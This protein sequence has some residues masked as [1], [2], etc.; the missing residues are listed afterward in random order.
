MCALDAPVIVAAQLKRKPVRRRI[1]LIVAGGL[2]AATKPFLVALA[3]AVTASA[4]SD[5]SLC[6]QTATP[7]SA[8]ETYLTGVKTGDRDLVL[9]VYYF[10]DGNEDFSLAAPMP[11]E[12][13]VIVSETVF[14][15]LAA[16]QWND[17]GIKPSAL[18]GDVELQ[19]R[20]P[21]SGQQHMFSYWLRRI[22]G[23]W[24]IY[25]HTV[26]DGP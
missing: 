26:W 18:P 12:E 25:A 22:D 5:G 4:T 24:R 21:I 7:R 14:D 16:N 9:S 15:S 3:L 17:Q 10:E 19:V 2:R 1:H 20:K 23:E 6:A 8:L 13:Y 11:L